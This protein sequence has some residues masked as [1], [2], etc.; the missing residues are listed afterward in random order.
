MRALYIIQLQPTRLKETQRT[1]HIILFGQPIIISAVSQHFPPPPLASVDQSLRF[2]SSGHASRTRATS[3]E[4]ATPDPVA[5]ALERDKMEIE[6]YPIY[7]R[8][9]VQGE[10]KS[11]T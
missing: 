1:L 8:V 2:G 11:W 10:G 3:I 4:F 7:I 5:N 9:P 6:G